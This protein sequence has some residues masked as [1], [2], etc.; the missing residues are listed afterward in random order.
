M[1]YNIIPLDT[2]LR[3][4]TFCNNFVHMKKILLLRNSIP[5]MIYPI[6]S[7]TYKTSKEIGYII[8]TSRY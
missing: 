6:R 2:R 1:I 4:A 3:K 7:N 5:S 8:A